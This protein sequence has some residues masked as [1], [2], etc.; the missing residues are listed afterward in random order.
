MVAKPDAREAGMPREIKE[1]FVKATTR[2]M[3]SGGTVTL[4]SAVSRENVS[5]E[6]ILLK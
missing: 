6:R 2:L 4:A 3:K 5:R 1:F